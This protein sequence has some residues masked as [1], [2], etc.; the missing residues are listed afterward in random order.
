VSTHPQPPAPGGGPAPWT[1]APFG[2]TSPP[3]VSLDDEETSGADRVVFLLA[4]V[5]GGVIAGFAGGALWA[6]LA[7]PPKA[8]ITGQGAFL[9]S[10]LSYN[11]RVTVTL[12]FLAVGVLGGI[13]GGAVIGLLGRRHG[14]ASVVAS[15]LMSAVASGLAA[16]SGIHVFGPD[17]PQPHSGAPGDYVTTALAITSDVAYLGWPIGAL[18]GV[19]LVTAVLPQRDE[20]APRPS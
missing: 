3:Q 9:V 15:L 13:V 1:G 5:L 11:A 7:D 6:A 14:P 12:W 17:G 18:L 19:L 10:E 20:N 4:S 2:A 8:L 16:W